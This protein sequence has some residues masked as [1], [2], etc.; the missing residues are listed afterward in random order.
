VE[1]ENDQSKEVLFKKNCTM[2]FL[3]KHNLAFLGSN[4]KLYEDTNGN[5]VG[6]VEMLDESNDEKV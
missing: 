5:F 4:I 2:K 3:A 6:L 1:K